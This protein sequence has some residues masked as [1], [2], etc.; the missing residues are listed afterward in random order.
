M[1]GL[2]LALAVERLPS[3]LTPIP[4]PPDLAGFVPA[5]ELRKNINRA[6]SLFFTLGTWKG[7]E[8]QAL[9]EP[10]TD[11]NG[12]WFITLPRHLETCLRGGLPGRYTLAT[13]GFW[14]QF[15]PNAGHIRL[16]DQVYLGSAP[17]DAGEGFCT[18]RDLLTPATLTI[19][20]DQTEV[21]ATYLWIRALDENGDKI[22]TNISGTIYEGIRITLSATPVVTTQTVSEIYGISKAISVGNITVTNGTDTLAI[23][24]PGERVPS[25]RRYIVGS[26]ETFKGIF[27]RKHCWAVADNDPL[28]PDSLTALERGLWSINCSDKQNFPGASAMMAEA[29]AILNSD[30]EQYN[31][32]T[33]GTLQPAAWLTGG[34][35]SMR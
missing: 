34:I 35:P 26:S 7:L 28:Y 33:E 10:Q 16:T 21:A 24:E 31:S 17:E 9:I 22:F 12:G 30:L 2:T 32:G 19:S 15:L 8:V 23:Y 18:F 14:W 13:R 27:R 6:T 4:D 29:I 25:Y 3:S 20:S 5:T 11:V 1:S